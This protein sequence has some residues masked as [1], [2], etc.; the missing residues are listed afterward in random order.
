MV[1][2]NKLEDKKNSEKNILPTIAK[3]NKKTQKKK[4][5]KKIKNKS[6]PITKAKVEANHDENANFE[7]KET[8]KVT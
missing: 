5:N 3:I 8:K 6:T 7:L 2:K 4:K 1:S